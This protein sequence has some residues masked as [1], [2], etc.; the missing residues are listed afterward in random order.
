MFD[1]T[2][3]TADLSK[4]VTDAEALGDKLTADFA[5]FPTQPNLARDRMPVVLDQIK[6][7]A[8]LIDALKV[9]AGPAPTPQP[10]GFP[11][12]ATPGVDLPPRSAWPTI[13]RIFT[14]EDRAYRANFNDLYRRFGAYIAACYAANSNTDLGN[15][16]THVLGLAQAASGAIIGFFKRDGQN[17]NVAPA[18]TIM[19]RFPGVT[20]DRRTG[21]Y[22]LKFDWTD[23][24]GEH[25][26]SIALRW[27]DTDGAV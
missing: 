5:S 12:P 11:L 27:P 8:S 14:A 23:G 26:A 6:G 9:L 2:A 19:P 13:G 25:H 7:I 17:A 20:R 18:G 15:D 4:I 1:S 16:L 3:R 24:A 21:A 22:T 10:T